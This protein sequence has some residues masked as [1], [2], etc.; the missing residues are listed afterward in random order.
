MKIFNSTELIQSIAPKEV[1]RCLYDGLSD[2]AKG[3]FTVP[4]RV[5]IQK[6]E[7][8]IL[9]MPALNEHY[10]STKIVSIIPS[11]SY[12]NLPLIQG[13]VSLSS[14]RTGE[15]LAHMDAATITGMRTAAIGAIGLDILAAKE[16]E[17][18]GI[19]GCGTQAFWQ[20]IYA[21][22]MRKINT[23]FCYTRTTA[24]FNRFAQQ[25]K[26]IHP[27]LKL[28][29]CTSAKEV[30]QQSD[31]IYTCTNS[32]VPVFEV[33]QAIA[34]LKN[35]IAIGSY[36]KDMQELPD[37]VFK[38]TDGAVLDTKHAIHES[39]DVL[40]PLELNANFELLELP[41]IIA[42]KNILQA[43]KKYFFKSVGHASF[44]LILAAAIY[45]KTKI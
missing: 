36:R 28:I 21:V 45:H 30:I 34:K 26:N 31:N 5:H 35:F 32:A 9:V 23:V 15:Q 16:I 37:E 43:G 44:D 33:D 24:N 42:G 29:L 17:N 2:F 27:Q 39:G 3:K 19:I 10:H 8:T 6:G 12:R 20:C 13:H 40:R 18:I 38:A 14:M 41:N 22:E 4:D 11:N 25:V 7:N 1:I